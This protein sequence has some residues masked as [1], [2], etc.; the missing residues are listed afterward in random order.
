[1]KQDDPQNTSSLPE[2]ER[3]PGLR[4]R[5][6]ADLKRRIAEATLGLV[7]ERGYDGTTIDEIVRRVQVSQPT[8]YAYYPSKDAVLREHAL[9]GFAA[10]LVAEQA[11][12]GGIVERMR[13]YFRA[14][15][16]QMTEDRDVWYAIAT[17][18]AYNPIRD[19][20]LLH[21]SA[22]ATRLLEAV[23]SEGQKTDEF[24]SELSALRLA[25]ALEGIMFR[26]CIEWG[27]AFPDD[28]PLTRRMDEAFELFLRA[29]RSQPGD[30]KRA[31]GSRKR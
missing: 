2:A 3:L 7:R 9:S 29:A 20:S 30:K 25:S 24:T 12:S 27:A 13:R 16:E 26:A 8:F 28:R 21:S 1:M 22:A 18:N 6:K 10:L 23:I 11:R 17:S 31:S 14:V 4:E 19:P 15:A 5:K